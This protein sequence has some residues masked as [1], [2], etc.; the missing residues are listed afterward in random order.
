MSEQIYK[1]NGARFRAASN[2]VIVWRDPRP[3]DLPESSYLREAA[4]YLT[5]HPE[6]ECCRTD[7]GYT[8][9]R[10]EAPNHGKLYNIDNAEAF[11]LDRDHARPVGP[12][13]IYPVELARELRQAVQ[14]LESDPGRDSYQLADGREVR[15]GAVDTTEYPTDP[16]TPE[17]FC[18]D[19]LILPHGGPNVA[20]WDRT[21]VKIDGGAITSA[22]HAR[23]VAEAL[24]EAAERM[25]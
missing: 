4:A 22:A 7:D 9:E 10:T 20:L 16:A 3:V 12:P 19:L 25:E 14:L 18:D 1:V 2:G 8:V 13:Y 6:A 15:R 23:L 24:L 17:P 21:E 5:A 11:T